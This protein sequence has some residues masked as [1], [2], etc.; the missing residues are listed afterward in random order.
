MLVQKLEWGVRG[1]KVSVVSLTEAVPLHRKT[2]PSKKI[3]Q[4]PKGNMT[5]SSSSLYSQLAEGN[6]H[7]TQ[8]L[9]ACLYMKKTLESIYKKCDPIFLLFI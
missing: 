7:T 4:P 6:L 1:Q 5:V 3:N 8:A 2:F 9:S